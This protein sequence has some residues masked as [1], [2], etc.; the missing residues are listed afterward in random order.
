[1][2]KEPMWRRYRR[3][4]GPDPRRD[5][6]DEL[7][8]HLAMREDEYRRA[9]HTPADARDS[10]V[11]RFG[12]VERIRNEC[13]ALGR[14]RVARRR[15]ASRW[16]ALRQDMRYALRMLR[17]NPGFSLAVVATMALG[18]GASSAVFSV[19]YGVLLR[20]LVYRDADALV[21]LWSSSA[22]RDLEF[23][24]I[25]TADY[26]DWK[27]QSR[28]FSTMGAFERQR[29]AVLT[30]GGG[31]QPIQVAAVT[32]DVFPLLGTPPAIGRSM[33]PDDA[34]AAASPVVVL[35]HEAWATRFGADSS[36]VG[37]DVAIDG[38]LHRVI[39][40][41][42][43]RF[44][45]P[46]T[47]AELWTPLSLAGASEDHGNRYL[48]VLARLAPGVDHDRA[49]LELGL[50]A[51]RLARDFPA[52]NAG[53][54]V[55]S[56]TVPEMI[57]GAQFR[58]AVLV[59]LGVVG[60]VL[61]IACANAANL[62]LARAAARAREIAV[63]SAL[64]AS[65]GR[66]LAQLLAESALLGVLAGLVGL[67]LAYGGLALL[68]TLAADMVP[69]LE[70]V[71]VDAPVLAFTLVV[72]LGGGL[73]FGLVPALRA[74][75]SD[76]SDTLKHGSR[77]SSGGLVGEG[78]RSAL[79]V[80]EV[81]L[82][83]ILLIGAGLLMRSFARL[84]R[85]ETGFD[86]KGVVVIPLRLPEASYADTARAIAFYDALLDQVAPLPGVTR[87]AA[88]SAAP[89]E[90]PNSGLVFSRVDRPPV[91]RQQAP[92]ADY[93]VVTPGYLATLGIPL[94][95]GRDVSPRDVAGAPGVAVI[96]EAMARR[97]W[98]AEDPVGSRVRVG[99]AVE[100]PVYTVVGVA[101]D[102]RYQSL[103]SPDARPMMYFGLAQNPQR[104]MTL[105]LRTT[106]AA[107]AAA[108]VRRVVASLDPAL[109]LAP[110]DDMSELMRQ[111]FATRRFALVLVGIFASIA[112]VLVAV[113][114]YGVL[115]FLVRRRTRELGIRVAL[116][117]PQGRL[118]ASVIGRALR[119]TV[120]G[121]ALGLLGAG[122]LSRSMGTLLFE[123]SATDRGIFAG[124]AALV[125]AVGVIASFVPARRAMRADPMEALRAE[126]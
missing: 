74:S 42:P 11:R 12:D 117:A 98:P 31:P 110:V 91:D 39:G 15:R 8:F 20:P 51:S 82:S 115:S 1:M 2:G 21:R 40:V 100:G 7:A 121:V 81:T 43:P 67:A 107:S 33:A 79:V 86:P 89:F 27:A 73:L 32:P 4:W 23:F 18:I 56:M 17:T 113:G 87:A 13:H 111:A 97:Y 126:A 104:S 63:R 70:D 64:G 76:L 72:A 58:R 47:P 66:I 112:T 124:V 29:E 35:S 105:V 6:D 88:V 123:T 85:V 19:A 65:R 119:M 34:R 108:G 16:D 116:G 125:I 28:A 77:G 44:T 93:R 45:V 36:A 14:E 102:A 83:L 96:S 92:D 109:A 30:L 24:S 49:R 106:D 48:R 55:T 3:F 54:T 46:G 60:F 9:G 101:R 41:M 53:W 61:L 68:R 71:R 59:L 122:Y 50:I 118:M 57:V 75:R 114:I 22:E 80:A 37:R 78:V 5:F 26:R 25:S 90:G 94:V 10:A 84:Q 103:E 62:Q 99:D 52:S 120:V 38:T 69:R 95:R